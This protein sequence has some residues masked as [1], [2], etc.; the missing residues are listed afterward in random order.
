MEFRVGGLASP[1]PSLGA[2]S[3]VYGYP[4]GKDVATQAVLSEYAF[5]T[6]VGKELPVLQIMEEIVEMIQLVFQERVQSRTVNSGTCPFPRF[7]RYH[8]SA[9]RIARWSRSLTSPRII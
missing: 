7:K 9:C 5:L 2:N 8:R 3:G 1:D 4:F 6:R